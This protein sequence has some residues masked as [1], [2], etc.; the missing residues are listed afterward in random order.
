[1]LPVRPFFGVLS[2]SLRAKV[3]LGV[4]LPLV[5]I[6]GTFTAVEYVRHRAAVLANLSLLASHSGQVIED[7]LRHEMLEAD[8][9]QV[10]GLLDMIGESEG[11][12]VVYVLDPSGRGFD[13]ATV[14][15]DGSEPRGLGL[16]GM[17]ERVALCGG[18]LEICSRPGAGTR[19]R[20]RIPLP[21]V[22]NG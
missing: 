6:L 13:P 10:Q 2:H 16:L 19:L 3:T 4:V 9:A 17:Q 21:E 22:N 7:N 8:L 11:F 12:R 5:L 14:S 18:T 1:M 20:I 15:A